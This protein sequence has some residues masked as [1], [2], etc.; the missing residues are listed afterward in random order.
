MQKRF[1]KR[2]KV[3]V[4]ESPAV[5]GDI[6][7]GLSEERSLGQRSR[8]WGWTDHGTRPKEASSHAG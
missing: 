3:E 7:V 6:G 1:R 5:Q 8:R 2:V 4:G